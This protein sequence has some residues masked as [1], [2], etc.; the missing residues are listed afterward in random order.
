MRKRRRNLGRA[1]FGRRQS[2]SKV[3]KTSQAFLP[4]LRGLRQ[5][6][7]HLRIAVGSP[8]AM[9]RRGF[10]GSRSSWC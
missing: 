9:S 8:Q 7:V 6:Q 1:S 3:G 5:Q 4:L 2:A 10:W